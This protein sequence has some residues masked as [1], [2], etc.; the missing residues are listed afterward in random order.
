M[1]LQDVQAGSI[2]NTCKTYGHAFTVR[3]QYGYSATP[4]IY[5]TCLAP[6]QCQVTR[7]HDTTLLIKCYV[8][9]DKISRAHTVK[10][11]IYYS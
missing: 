5:T 3:L 11:I 10:D 2:V 6:L 7:Q 4:T 8:T 9:G 1:H